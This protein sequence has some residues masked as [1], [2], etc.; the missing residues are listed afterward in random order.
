MHGVIDSSSSSSKRGNLERDLDQ[1]KQVVVG[2]SH[3]HPQRSD[4][5]TLPWQNS[6][7]LPNW[8]K[9][10]AKWHRAQRSQMN[11]SNWRNYG[12]AIMQCTKRDDSC[13]GTA[14][15]LKPFL[16]ALLVAHQTQR[17]LFIHWETPKPLQ[18]FLVP[19]LHG[20]DWRLPTYVRPSSGLFPLSSV[21]HVERFFQKHN[22]SISSI[23]NYPRPIFF[24][25]QLFDGGASYYD[26]QRPDGL[27]FLQVYRE[28]W[29]HVMFTPIVEIQRRIQQSLQEMNLRPGQYTAAHVRAWYKVETRT[30]MFLRDLS[31]NA[32]NCASQLDALQPHSYNNNHNNNHH[33]HNK[34]DA[35]RYFYVASDSG[36]VVERALTYG[37]QQDPQHAVVVART[38]E[39]PPLHLEKADHPELRNSSE[40]YD[41]FVD[42]YLMALSRCVTYNKGGFGQLA[43]MLSYNVSCYSIHHYN[44]IMRCNW[45]NHHDEYSRATAD[46][47]DD[48][49]D[50]SSVSEPLFPVPMPDD[51]PLDQRQRKPQQPTKQQQEEQ[52]PLIQLSSTPRKRKHNIVGRSQIGELLH[53][54]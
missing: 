9:D 8:L 28:A 20:I 43:H 24:R 45:T 31:H 49:G 5:V 47:H 41:I 6:T 1:Q 7:L 12:F 46:A 3:H 32:L 52:S 17:L 51:R 30:R 16:L 25:F 21:R 44:K 23:Q 2:P 39:A 10:Y 29:W 18:D 42:L 11:A 22:Y 36:Y 35:R 26:E 19:P 37:P 34:N 33:N 14:D 40:Y 38:H 27:P 13:G 50:D 48:T 54:Y 4:G 53:T 15:R